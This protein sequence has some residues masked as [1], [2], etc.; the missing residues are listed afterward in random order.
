MTELREEEAAARPSS[1][2][3]FLNR[4]SFNFPNL[5]AQLTFWPVLAAGLA[6]DLWTKKAVFDHLQRQGSDSIP[7]IDG[8]LQ[9]VIRLNKGAA[10]G[11]AA[12]QTHLLIVI[13]LVALVVIFAIFFFGGARQTL[14]HIALGLFAAGVCGNLYDRIFHDGFVRDFI[15]VAYW[16]RKHW[17]AFNVAD[18]M[19]CVAVALLIISNLFTG[20][21]YRKRA[22]QHK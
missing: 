5:R 10:F 20:T 19:L 12:G 18:T 13:S 7:I 11:I 2:R 21:S 15:D 14:A 6:L 16:P 9:F 1:R 22:P 3:V 17:P 8:F 4:L